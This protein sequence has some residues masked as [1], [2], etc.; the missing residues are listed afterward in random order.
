MPLTAEKLK[1][2]RSTLEKRR[3]AL[4]AE[5]EDDAARVRAEPFAA[6]A[7]ESPDAG[8]ESVADAIA[9]TDQ[10]DLNRDLGELRAVEAALDRFEVNRYGFCKECGVEIPL[11]RLE[12]NPAASRCAAC[13]GR[14]EKTFR[15]TKPATL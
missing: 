8:D 14:H 7:G 5:L 15:G 2:L 11:A 10:A 9:D 1:A 4:I 12:A 3:T 13:Q 6:L